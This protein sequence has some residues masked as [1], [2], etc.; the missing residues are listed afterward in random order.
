MSKIKKKAKDAV[1]SYV[2]PTPKWWKIVRNICGMISG[3][4][5]ALMPVT[6]GASGI[7]GIL[8]VVANIIAGSK[9]LSKEDVER[10]SKSE[11][12]DLR[13]HLKDVTYGKIEGKEVEA[14]GLVLDELK[15][16]V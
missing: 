4:G 9:T 10:M 6:G 3:I 15:D 1:E 2:A 7:V 14:L 13:D 11:L 16:R 12:Q 8:A 5:F